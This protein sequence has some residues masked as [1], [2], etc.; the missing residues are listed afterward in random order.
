M[1]VRHEYHAE[2]DLLPLFVA[3]RQNKISIAPKITCPPF[4]MS[5]RVSVIK[6]VRDNMVSDIHT[7]DPDPPD[8]PPPH[9]ALAD[10]DLK[11]GRVFNTELEVFQF[12]KTYSSN[13]RAAFT[14]TSNNKKQVRKYLSNPIICIRIIFVNY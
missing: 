12:V 3:S 4:Q 6:T 8:H 11:S 7:L 13:V 14:C 9:P 10:A 1:Q 2:K 5:E